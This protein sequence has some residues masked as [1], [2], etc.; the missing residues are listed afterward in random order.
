MLEMARGASMALDHQAF[1]PL[2][3]ELNEQL[4]LLSHTLELTFEERQQSGSYGEAVRVGTRAS[5]P[6]NP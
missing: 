4:S 5:K 2:R 6:G 3:D 1:C